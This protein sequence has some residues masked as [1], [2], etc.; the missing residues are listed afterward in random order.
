MQTA[1]GLSY[2]LGVDERSESVYRQTAAD[3]VN[4]ELH[5][6]LTYCRLASSTNNPA[7]VRRNSENAKR[8]LRALSAERLLDIGPRDKGIIG[9]KSFRVESLPVELTGRATRIAD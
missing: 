8:A 1:S 5:L 7:S 2:C 3:F 6:A 9:E 4:L